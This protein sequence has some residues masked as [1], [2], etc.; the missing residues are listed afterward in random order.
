MK[1]EKAWQ[2]MS[3]TLE[4]E[5][6]NNEIRQLSGLPEIMEDLES[7]MAQQLLNNKHRIGEIDRL[8][9]PSSPSGK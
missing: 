2:Q 4:K 8:L 1:R 9:K 3:L 7:P 6:L 5:H